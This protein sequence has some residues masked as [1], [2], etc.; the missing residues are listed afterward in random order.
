[1]VNLGGLLAL[2][3]ARST[4]T[5]HTDRKDVKSQELVPGTKSPVMSS[6]GRSV[7]G[8]R[9]VRRRRRLRLPRADWRATALRAAGPPQDC[10]LFAGVA[11]ATVVK[12]PT[13]KAELRKLALQLRTT[14]L[15]SSLI[16]CGFCSNLASLRPPRRAPHQQKSIGYLPKKG[17]VQLSLFSSSHVI[18]VRNIGFSTLSSIA[19]V[20]I[21]YGTVLLNIYKRDHLSSG[22]LLL[23]LLNSN[24]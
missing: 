13:A 20:V 23:T 1:M 19:E 14:Y 8:T 10:F 22:T 2:S 16:H 6:P 11:V 4:F 5:Q 18:L 3:F 21:M 15:G 7:P 9:R 24:M 12:T 17:L